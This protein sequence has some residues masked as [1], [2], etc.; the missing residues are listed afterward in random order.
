MPHHRVFGS[1]ISCFVG[2]LPD[3]NKVPSWQPQLNQVHVRLDFQSMSTLAFENQPKL[4]FDHG[5]LNRIAWLRYV[6]WDY[7]RPC[8]LNQTGKYTAVHLSLEDGSLF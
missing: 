8:P 6:R 1:L 3:R 7:S 4:S 5:W 2:R